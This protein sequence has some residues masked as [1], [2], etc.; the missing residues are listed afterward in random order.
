MRFNCNFDRCILCLKNPADSWEHI[1]P[2]SIG[3]RLQINV[4]CSSCNNTLGSKL[5]SRVKF[6]SSIRLAIKSLKNTIPKLYSTVEN[7]QLY[8]AKNKQ[9]NLVELRYKN[10]KFR[11]VSHTKKD[12]S[13][14]LDSHNNISDIEQMLES[15]GLSE[16]RV[17]DK[18]SFLHSM[19]ENKVYQL[20]ETVKVAKWSIESMSPSLK[21]PVLDGKIIALIA[22]EFLSLLLGKTIYDDRLD[23][24]RVFINGGGQ[25]PNLIIERLTSRQ[26]GPLHGIYPEFLDSEIIINVILF[27]WLV[28]K[29]HLTKFRL[30]SNNYVYSE[31]LINKK[32]CIAESI[33]KAKQGVY[34]FNL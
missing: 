6:D 17:K 30:K 7:N 16:N 23:F 8:D 27:R 14:I 9:G 18:I 19:E 10:S 4:L 20:S 29:V 21:G 12:G 22:Y 32:T 15:D 25:S 31:D 3:G 24:I 1:I 26:Y 33:D 2:E 11:V 13:L 28:F 5:V 34:L